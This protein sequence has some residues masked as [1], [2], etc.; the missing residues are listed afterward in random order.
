MQRALANWQLTYNGTKAEGSRRWRY[1]R[2]VSEAFF[3][4]GRACRACLKD[5]DAPDNGGVRQQQLPFCGGVRSVRLH[6][7]IRLGAG[8]KETGGNRIAI[9]ADIHGNRGYAQT[10][11]STQ[12]RTQVAPLMSAMT[13]NMVATVAG[14]SP[15]P[16]NVTFRRGGKHFRA[17]PA[18]GFLRARLTGVPG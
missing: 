13:R 15:K 9:W 17:F 12:R 5:S 8:S 2:E 18:F 7:R 10:Q 4:R 16:A 14:V 1:G 6:H 11:R 3:S